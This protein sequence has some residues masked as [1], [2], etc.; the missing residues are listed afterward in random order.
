MNYMK[1]SGSDQSNRLKRHKDDVTT[2]DILVAE[3]GDE[4]EKWRD[5]FEGAE[6][7]GEELLD[8]WE[9]IKKY[10]KKIETWPTRDRRKAYRELYRKLR[11][12][13]QSGSLSMMSSV[14]S[15]D[16]PLLLPQLCGSTFGT[17]NQSLSAPNSPETDSATAPTNVADQREETTEED[18]V[19]AFLKAHQRI[20]CSDFV[21][22]HIPEFNHCEK[23]EAEPIGAVRRIIE[24]DA[25]AIVNSTNASKHIVIG[26]DKGLVKGYAMTRKLRDRLR[27]AIDSEL[28]NWDPPP[29]LSKLLDVRFIDI[30]SSANRP[31]PDHCVI[32]ITV[33]HSHVPVKNSFGEIAKIDSKGGGGGGSSFHH[34]HHR[35]IRRLRK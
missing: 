35:P 32:W 28:Q 16:S 33:S 25:N 13:T 2:V 7:D 20:D 26:V 11:P 9:H 27:I 29:L 4:W 1:R 17:A 15:T 22:Y 18:E 14:R 21:T 6:L 34:R 8:I 3:Y 10:K 30:H 19:P 5:W 23:G 24:N 31:I 12:I